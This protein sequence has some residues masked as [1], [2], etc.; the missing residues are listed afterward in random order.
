MSL[1]GIGLALLIIGILLLVFTALTNLGW[2]AV[3]VGGI[4]TLV[5]AVRRA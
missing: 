1:A 5:A 2:A 3:I 4:I